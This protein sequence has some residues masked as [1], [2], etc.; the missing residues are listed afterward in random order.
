M[1]S[2]VA[3]NYKEI[4]NLDH[5]VNR[6]ALLEGVFSVKDSGIDS[7]IFHSWKIINL[8]PT[9]NKGGWAD[10]SFIDLLWLETLE[11]MRKFGCSKNL[12]KDV[13]NHLFYKAYEIN[14]GKKRL[15]DNHKYLTNLSLERPLE[16]EEE[17]YLKSINQVINDPIYMSVLDRGINYFYELVVECLTKNCEVGLIIYL[18]GSFNT[19][20]SSKYPN[21]D[22]GEVDLSIPH[23]V[24]PIGSFIKKFITDD[25][26]E[27]FLKQSGT[28][29][30][31]EFELIRLIRTKNLKKLIVSFNNSEIKKIETEQSGLIPEDDVKIIKKILGLKNYDRIEI[32]SRD[33]RTL[34]FIK[35][36][37]PFMK[38]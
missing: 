2:I 38:K 5:V 30:E 18:N 32:N 37:I 1:K 6:G 26:K 31:Q 12:M 33:G 22:V 20:V 14:L 35:T 34:S 4:L 15:E 23:I 28:L 7:K 21:Q 8:L 19:Y 11:T 3:D 9:V 27:D 17:K 13:C 10:L 16:I 29:N 36:K 25:S 24:I